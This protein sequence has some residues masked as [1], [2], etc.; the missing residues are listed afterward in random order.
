MLRPLQN[1]FD[2][3]NFPQVLVG[4]D[5]PDD[6]AV[7]QLNDEQAIVSTIDFF[8]PVVDDPYTF[9]S[10]AAAN[11]MSDVYAMGGEVLFA[12][13]LAA[14]P[15]DLDRAI[16]TEILR[17]GAEKVREAGAIITGGD[18]GRG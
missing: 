9:G 7:Y 8:P 5:G 1:I 11:A 12:L 18:H 4:L 17:G 15:D 3:R 14:F 16:L 10:I 13:N 2:E 6:A